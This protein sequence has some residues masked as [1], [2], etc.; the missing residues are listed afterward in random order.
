MLTMS[1]CRGRFNRRVCLQ[2]CGAGLLGLVVNGPR[3]AG[4]AESTSAIEFEKTLFAEREAF[5]R[6]R[7]VDIVRVGFRPV[8]GKVADFAVAEYRGRFHFFYIERRLQEGTPFYPGHEI[9]LGHAST[10]DFL[11]WEVHDPAMIVRPDSWEEAH[12]WAPCIVRRG[13]RFV[14]AYTGVNRHISQDIGFASSE[15]LFTWQRWES[16]PLSPCKGKSW[17]FWRV[18]GISSC[19][20][21]SICAYGGFYWLIYTANTREGASCIA[22]VSST[23]FRDWRDHGPICVG[24]ADGYEARLE[25]GHP[26]GS[27]ESASLLNR[28]G[29]WILLVKAKVRGDNTHSWIIE[30]D[31]SDAFDFGRRRSFWPGAVGIEVIRDRGERSLL[32]TFSEGFI[33]LGVVDWSDSR[34]TGR[35]IA[36]EDELKEWL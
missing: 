34:P 10:V 35:F 20:D 29:R 25:G 27:L 23:D 15:D 28:S 31:R 18:D 4:A 26:Q 2:G 33:R 7:R 8:G 30:S 21:P 16:N 1:D 3:A 22:M 17:A 13:D 12:L 19:R 11:D 36:R 24:P 5:Y 6:R 32:S 9:Y 14:M